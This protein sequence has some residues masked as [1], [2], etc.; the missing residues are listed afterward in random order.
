MQ[1]RKWKST[2]EEISALGF[3]AMRFPM[4][5]SDPEKVD[6]DEA[7]R[8]IRRAI[9]GGVNYLDTAWAY[10]EGISE[11]ICAKAMKDGY[12]Q[13]V[14]IATKLPSWEIQSSKEMYHY[15][16]EQRKRLEVETIDYYLLHTLRKEYWEIYKK[17]D[18][19]SFLREA[20]EKG[21]IAHYGF[22]FHDDLELFKEIVDDFDWEFV[23]IQLNLLD[24]NY[25]AG[26]EGMRYAAS[27]GMD[28]IIME[29][30][31]GG[32]LA[33]QEIKGPLK[34]ILNSYKEPRTMAEWALRYLWNYPEVSLVLSGM[35]NQDQ[36]DE[37]MATAK[38]SLP[39]SLDQD[40]Q[41]V[42]N[43]IKEYYL[44]RIKV[45]CTQCRYCMPCPVG[46]NIPESFWAYNH[47]GLFD[48]R[49]KAHFWINVFLTEESRPSRC[50]EC[51]ECLEKCPQ[52]IAIP[53]ELAKIRD[54]LED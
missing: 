10:H 50:I 25:Q 24:E 39:L 8:L 43:K 9:D 26:L 35:S 40:E 53:D 21:W 49:G 19:K 48:D 2:G 5:A 3:G 32:T 1:Y 42:L 37:N 45:N 7:V 11:E 44:S 12:R 46:V 34:E 47:M 23:Q 6:Q 27:K 54:L 30:L 22:S 20:K 29:P 18:Y 31:R 52:N 36:L 28:V 33:P 15:L 41:Y 51:G 14:N 16:E 4:M 13:R 17:C 38:D